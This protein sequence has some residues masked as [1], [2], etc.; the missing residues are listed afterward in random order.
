MATIWCTYDAAGRSWV[1]MKK[2]QRSMKESESRF[3]YKRSGSRSRN[4]RQR[5]VIRAYEDSWNHRC[6]LLFCCMGSTEQNRNSFADIA[7]LLS[8]FFRDLDVVPSDV[9]AGLVLLR[10][11][12]ILEREA[13]V[14]QRK[15]GTFEFLSGAAITESTQFLALHQSKDFEHFQNVIHYMHFAQSAY[16]WPIYLITHSRTGL[17]QLCSRVQCCCLLPSIGCCSSRRREGQKVEVEVISD[18]CC[19]CNYGA[20]QKMLPSGDIEVIYVT[21]HVDVGETPFLVA[22]DYTK[23]KIVISIRG[24]LSMKDIL[25]DLNAEGECLPL[26]PP[27]EDWFGHKG[28]VQA[29]VYIKN[30]LEEENLISR[31]LGHSLERGTNKFDLVIVGHSL[32]AGTAAILAILLRGQYP[33]LTCFSFSPPG[34]LLR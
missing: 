29:A 26:E 13:I 11:F 4:W 34:G 32:G 21:Y 33:S 15:N 23:Q 16:G 6:R 18:N 31:A 28:M 9:I 24:T 2:Y 8:D 10:K 25:T 5:K 22:V 27:R 20:L 14:R 1:K 30:K 12:Q 7:R 19:G 17:C 3:N